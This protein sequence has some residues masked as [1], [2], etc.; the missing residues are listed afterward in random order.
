MRTFLTV[1][2]GCFFAVTAATAQTGIT[3]EPAAGLSF[4]TKDNFK[5]F[6]ET[7]LHLGGRAGY[8]ITEN[9]S[10]T[11]ALG[12]NRYSSKDQ[13]FPEARLAKG[14]GVE[15][16]D[17]DRT[18]SIVGI[19]GGV[20]YGGA[21]NETIGYFAGAEVGPVNQKTSFSNG[22][23]SQWDF[24]FGFY[25]GARYFFT[26]TT[27]VGFGPAFNLVTSDGESYHYLDFLI[28]VLFSI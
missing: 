22:S 26:P 9:I 10:V 20:Q 15:G 14:N 28:S 6:Y 24:G 18:F 16:F 7:G 19:K 13:F 21:V 3:V 5:D 8:A 4:P 2:L 23:F 17:P 27:A 12:Y 11:A 25:G 1:L